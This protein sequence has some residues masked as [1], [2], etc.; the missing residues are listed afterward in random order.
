MS[1]SPKNVIRRHLGKDG[2]SVSALGFGSMGL[3]AAYGKVPPDE[4]SLDV[5]RKVCVYLMLLA[6]RNSDAL[7]GC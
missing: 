2:P 6:N 5:L 1:T 3:S 7:I 4:E